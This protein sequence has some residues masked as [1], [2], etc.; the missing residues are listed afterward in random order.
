MADQAELQH[1]RSLKEEWLLE[2]SA[3]AG[4]DTT[5]RWKQYDDMITEKNRQIA[6]FQAELATLMQSVETL[7]SQKS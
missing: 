1:L 4:P 5:R 3:F 7:T 2:M 6:T